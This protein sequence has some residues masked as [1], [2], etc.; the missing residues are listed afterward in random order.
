MTMRSR[1]VSAGIVLGLVLLSFPRFVDA[2]HPWQKPLPPETQTEI[3]AVVGPVRHH[4]PT[5]DLHIVVVWVPRDHAP[6]FHE[7]EKFKEDW[8]RLLG[9]VPR[10]TVEAA[11]GYPTG[12]Q[13]KRANLV[14]FYT[15]LDYLSEAHYEPMDAFLAGGGGMIILH[16]TLIQRPKGEA[17]AQRFGLA[18]NHGT[19]QWGLLPTPVTVDTSHPI[20]RGLPEAL[21]FADEYYW[22]L[23]GDP[24]K[25]RVLGTAPAGPPGRTSRPH[26]PDELD[27]RAWPVF[28]TKEGVG[29]KGKVFVSVIGHN[30]FTYQNPYFRIILLRGLAWVVGEDWDPFKPL[31]TDG[32]ELATKPVGS[33]SIE[34]FAV[35]D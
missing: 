1:K 15:H 8:S 2:Q 35:L 30:Y 21:H 19:S 16:E 34:P 10:V 3:A 13:W 22:A 23:T 17:L 25:I 11:R 12:E 33:R 9:K 20:F 7:Y 14:V 4:E 27:D 29:G 6:G 18:W 26:R 31:V 28:W 24:A 32:I 5:R